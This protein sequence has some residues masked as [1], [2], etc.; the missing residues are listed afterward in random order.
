MMGNQ[1]EHEAIAPPSWELTPENE[2]KTQLWIKIQTAMNMIIEHGD[3]DGDHHKAW[4]LD[5]VF[6]ILSGDKYKKIV[7]GIKK[8]GYRWQEGIAP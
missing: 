5:Q 4:C 3:H 8:E 7:K 1:L 2:E 6:R